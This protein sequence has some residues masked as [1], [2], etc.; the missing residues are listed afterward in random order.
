MEPRHHEREA[1]LVESERDTDAG[2]MDQSGANVVED[3]T[4][5]DDEIEDKDDDED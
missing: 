4:G 2:D 1:D 5:H 3:D